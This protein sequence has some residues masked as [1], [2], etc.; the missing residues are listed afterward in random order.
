[1]FLI[2]ANKRFHSYCKIRKLY[3]GPLFT[4]KST[5]FG[6]QLCVCVCVCV[7]V[8]ACVRACVRACVYSLFRYNY[9]RR[10]DPCFI[11]SFSEPTIAYLSTRTQ[12][13]LIFLITDTVSNMELERW[14][15]TMYGLGAWTNAVAR[16]W[17]I[18]NGY[19]N[20][21]GRNTTDLI[22]RAHSYGLK[23]CIL[24]SSLDTWL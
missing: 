4:N 17:T 21:I 18:E 12:L 23:V 2:S 19:K 1:M 10:Q 11:Q 15:L 13:P 6:S 20:W 5:S 3:G 16:H 9:T 14:A 8:C 22:S 24:S 7:C